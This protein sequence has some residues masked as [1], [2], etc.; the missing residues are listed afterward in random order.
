M[1]ADFKSVQ[2]FCVYAAVSIAFCYFY[3]LTIFCGFLC[4]HTVRMKKNKNA[5]LFCFNQENLK[6]LANS[7]TNSLPK[8]NFSQSIEM[9]HLNGNIENIVEEKTFKKKLSKKQS[10]NKIVNFFFKSYK[11]LLTHKLGKM[12]VVFIYFLY[13]FLSAWSASHIHEGLNLADLVAKSSY[14]HSYI[15]DN[16]NMINLTPIVMFVVHQPIDYDDMTNRA[17]IRNL[18]EKAQ[19]HNAVSKTF[20]LSWLEQYG[21]DPIEYK[22]D[23]ANLKENLRFF[24]PYISDVVIEPISNETKTKDNR[25]KYQITASRFYVQISHVY[26][27]SEDAKTMSYLRE[28]CQ[29]SGLPV[30][31]HAMP[32]RYYEQ[33]EKTLPNI[34][35]A[36][37]ISSE[38]MFLIALI[39]IPDLVSVIC[40]IITMCSIMIG[41]IGAMTIMSLSLSTITMIIV[42]MSIGFCIDFSAH[43]VH[44][45]IVDSG[46]GDRNIRAYRACLHVGIPIFSSAFST[47]LGVCL[48]AFCESYIFKAFFKLISVLMVLGVINSLFFLPVLLTFV[49]PHWKRH[50]EIDNSEKLN[51]NIN[52]IN[53]VNEDHFLD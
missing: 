5:F 39:F 3:Q 28:T 31:T 6:C 16:I 32:F 2:I 30:I 8:N 18:L 22:Y 47:F 21:Q 49:G 46:K 50:K 38:A 1:I 20:S 44:A 52:I 45:F 24:P 51:K 12:I 10:S 42:V 4:V 33:F 37:V 19:Q 43:I 7:S 53:R 9:S 23:I 26:Y 34:L 25:Q 27:S 15:T 41:L 36:F 48:L 11:F 14:Y 17:K 13:I 40:I 35:Q 29:E